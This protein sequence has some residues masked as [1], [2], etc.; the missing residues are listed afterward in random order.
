MSVK[1]YIIYFIPLKNRMIDE[2][3]DDSVLVYKLTTIASKERFTVRTAMMNIHTLLTNENISTLKIQFHA[4]NFSW[5]MKLNCPFPYIE[6]A[7]N[8]AASPE[9]TQQSDDGAR[10]VGYESGCALGG[11]LNLNVAIGTHH[12]RA[13]RS[14]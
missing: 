11:C 10:D 14:H 12:V 3:G 1:T 4:S 7:R 5:I 9:A 6:T 2:R 13:S 8:K